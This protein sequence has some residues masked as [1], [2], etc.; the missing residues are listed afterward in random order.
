MSPFVIPDSPWNL[1]SVIHI[2]TV[3]KIL[4]FQEPAQFASG[5]C[6]FVITFQLI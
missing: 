6:G 3:D 1:V 5:K 4:A 2:G